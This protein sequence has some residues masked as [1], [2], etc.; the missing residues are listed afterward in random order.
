MS[1]SGITLA[2]VRARRREI[3]RILAARG[4]T[5]PRVF[6]S[7]ARGTADAKSDV[8]LLVDLAEPRP[9]GF[10]Y[11]GL[12]VELEEELARILG[13]SVH[14]TEC[15]GQSPDFTARALRDAVAL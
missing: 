8:D 13:R 3:L 14:V 11:V 4:A 1:A 15:Q 7:V 5:K 10:H 12:I 6:G 2:E 9:H